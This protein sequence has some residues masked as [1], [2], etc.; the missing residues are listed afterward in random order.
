MKD[1]ISN[2]FYNRAGFSVYR[3][4]ICDSVPLVVDLIGPP[5]IGKSYLIKCLIKKSV[6]HASRQKFD[7]TRRV[8]ISRAY[9]LSLAAT[10]LDD[11]G[12][13]QKKSIKILYDLN[14]HSA[15]WGV[16]VDEGLSQHFINELCEMSIDSPDNFDFI[17]RRRAVINLAASPTFINNR[18]RDRAA[19]SG[20]LLSYHKG[21][22]DEEL[23]R[24]NMKFLEKG[25]NLTLL[26][27]ER[28]FPA[29]TIDASMN[30][31]IVVEQIV[32]FLSS[33]TVNVLIK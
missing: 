25:E 17:M 28:Y 26:M 1:T 4:R 19:K 30:D 33:L 9:L 7:Q 11:I 5:G 23:S 21:K 6:I 12:V 22:T 24:F 14:I 3:W 31:D 10:R 16:L 18:I 29:V 20:A 2:I 27:K 13:L 8:C 15:N 32:D